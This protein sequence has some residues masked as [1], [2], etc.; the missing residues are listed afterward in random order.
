M[1]KNIK[2]E[3]AVLIFSLLPCLNVKP[4]VYLTP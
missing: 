4:K 2:T 3:T 1:K